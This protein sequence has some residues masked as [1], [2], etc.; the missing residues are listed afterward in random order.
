MLDETALD[1]SETE[2][3]QMLDNLDAFSPEEQAE[4]LKITEILERR[5]HAKA[6]IDDLIAFCQHMH[7]IGHNEFKQSLIVRDHDHRAFG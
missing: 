4:I 1:F 2:V 7:D 6:C 3:Q 5:Q